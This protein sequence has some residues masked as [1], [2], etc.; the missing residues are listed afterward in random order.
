MHLQMSP[1]SALLSS[2][3]CC[4][5][6][7][8]LS[9]SFFPLS[10]PHIG[11]SPFFWKWL[12]ALKRYTQHWLHVRRVALIFSGLSPTTSAL[13]TGPFT[14]LAPTFP[15][16]W[17]LWGE[18][19]SRSTAPNVKSYNMML[20]ASIIT[21]CTVSTLTHSADHLKL[22]HYVPDHIMWTELRQTSKQDGR[23][24]DPVVAKLTYSR[25]L[26]AYYDF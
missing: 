2:V 7:W 11:V 14:W 5:W 21:W 26:K 1:I 3:S 9:F 8:S 17:A 22:S 16:Y 25:T 19:P 20:K 10:L 6:Y 24:T 23:E 12:R 13:E 15:M 18:A 4:C